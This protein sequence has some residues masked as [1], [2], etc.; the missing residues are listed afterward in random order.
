MAASPKAWRGTFVS[1][2]NPSSSMVM[3]IAWRPDLPKVTF[4]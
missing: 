2:P 1:N 4:T 3:A